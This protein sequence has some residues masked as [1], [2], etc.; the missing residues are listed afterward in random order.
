MTLSAITAA[1]VAQLA[2]RYP[3]LTVE[4]HGGQFTERELPIL[5]AKTPA[6]L[7]AIAG[8][9]NLAPFLETQWRADLRWTVYVLGADVPADPGE[10]PDLPST[11]AQPRAVL[12]SDTTFDLLLWLP[13]QRWS[14]P[15]ARPP[16][17]ES[18]AADNLY[19]GHVNILRVALWAVTWT[20]SFLF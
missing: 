17:L 18:F 7:V 6:L 11:P 20:Q 8:I 9:A 14:V 19:T 10:P 16:D 13:G 1:I 15:G 12:A 4:A 5:L 2:A 3:A